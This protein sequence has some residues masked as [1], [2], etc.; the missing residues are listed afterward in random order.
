MF[1]FQVLI[2]MK[3]KPLHNKDKMTTDEKLD[4][5]MK[6]SVSKATYRDTQSPSDP[7]EYKRVYFGLKASLVSSGLPKGSSH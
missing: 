7:A 3:L 5:T 4:M 6:S 1:I 2:L